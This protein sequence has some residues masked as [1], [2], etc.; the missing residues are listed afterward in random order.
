MKQLQRACTPDY[1]RRD[2][3]HNSSNH[4]ADML[5]LRIGAMEAQVSE[6]ASQVSGNVQVINEVLI[7]QQSIK[8]MLSSLL[9]LNQTRLDLSTHQTAENLRGQRCSSEAH[10]RASLYA[11]H[12]GIAVSGVAQPCSPRDHQ[13]HV[14]S[15]PSWMTADTV[16][17][18]SGGND[19]VDPD[20]ECTQISRGASGTHVLNDTERLDG[21]FDQVGTSNGSAETAVLPCSSAAIPGVST[22]SRVAVAEIGTYNGTSASLE[23][24]KCAPKEK[25]EA[26]ACNR[27]CWVL[28][29]NAGDEIIGEGR[30]GG[31]WKSS[32][33]KFGH[34]CAYGEQ[35]VQLHKVFSEDHPLLYREDRNSEFKT[36]K[37]AV[38]KPKYSNVYIKWDSRYLIA[39]PLT[40]VPP[41]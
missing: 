16:P 31:S 30:A 25:A 22:R 5:S 39:K 9:P 19:I 21:A 26:I 17:I 10:G 4:N 28:H 15:P 40:K 18:N 2:G 1:S 11:A 6:M 7:A 13:S 41:N 29:P 34:L 14:P 35:M 20:V 27:P 3:N 38:V 37:D 36:I 23:K 12:A 24:T 32:T 33:T 8:E